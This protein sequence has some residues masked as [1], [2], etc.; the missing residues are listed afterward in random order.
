MKPGRTPC[1]NPR[2]QRTGP[3]EKFTGEMICGK[4]FSAL[5]AKIRAEHRAFWRALRKWD[6]R[7]A[8]TVDAIK[9]ERMRA[10]R[11]RI[12]FRLNQHWDTEI[13]ALLLAPEKPAGLESF[14]EEL[15]LA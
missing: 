2:C 9:L 14:M 11:Q 3:A 8:R 6:R 13:K 4:C 15:G 1:I 12:A 5:P 7:I 10:I